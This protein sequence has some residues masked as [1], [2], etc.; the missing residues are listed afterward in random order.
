MQQD[1]SRPCHWKSCWS[2]SLRHDNEESLRTRKDD[3]SEERNNVIAAAVDVCF[4]FWLTTRDLLALGHQ[5]KIQLDNNIVYD[6]L[7]MVIIASAIIADNL[8][9]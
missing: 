3:G 6:L 4:Q 7:S 1:K 9:P 5:L 2:S 8:K